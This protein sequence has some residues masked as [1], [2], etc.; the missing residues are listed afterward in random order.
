MAPTRTPSILIGALALLGLG[1][2]V[3]GLY[4]LTALQV[5]T[6]TREI[7][8]RM[9]L[10]AAPEAVVRALARRALGVATLGSA[11]GL[12]VAVACLPRLRSIL[13]G[14]SSEDFWTSAA[15]IAGLFLVAASAGSFLPARRAARIDPVRSLRGE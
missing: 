4:S 15:V 2:A 6:S 7:G 1:I 8:I 13:H 3:V 5:S 14:V 11:A 10:G 9:A 12:V